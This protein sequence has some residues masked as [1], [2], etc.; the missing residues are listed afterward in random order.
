MNE[1]RLLK[2]LLGPH[3]S[4]KA[5]RVGDAF[6]Q[7]VFKVAR[8]ASKPEIKSAVELLFEVKVKSVAT[9]NVK[10]KHKRFGRREGRRKDWKKAYVTLEP[11][12]QIDFLGAGE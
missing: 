8:D 2:V 3:I 11:G 6:N 5:A 12:Q 4:E 7:V 1:E 9:L 10:G